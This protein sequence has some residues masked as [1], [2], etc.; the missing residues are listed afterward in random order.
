MAVGTRQ[1]FAT[2]TFVELCNY[3]CSMVRCEYETDGR[4][5][6]YDVWVETWPNLSYYGGYHAIKSIYQA[7][8][9]LKVTRNEIKST[10]GS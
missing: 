10:S 1:L 7:S 5:Y 8:R 2:G 9:M 4:D 3:L 6:F